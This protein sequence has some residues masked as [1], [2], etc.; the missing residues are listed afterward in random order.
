MPPI[1]PDVVASWPFVFLFAVLFLIVL[2]A[3]RDFITTMRITQKEIIGDLGKH[4]DRISR[5]E[6]MN[7]LRDEKRDTP[8]EE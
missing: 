5:L 4:H 6:I 7:G 8:R 2:A 3:A 1:P